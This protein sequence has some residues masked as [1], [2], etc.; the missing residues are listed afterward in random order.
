MGV[1]RDV[2]IADSDEEAKSLWENSAVF[3]G[4]NWF[5]PFGFFKGI[6]DPQTGAMPD[7]FEEGLVL[8]GTVDTVTRQL[9]RLLAR[10]PAAWIFAWL[11]NG[12][13]SNDRL[14]K[15]IELFYTKVLPRVSDVRPS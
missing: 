6:L 4:D 8:V 13:L 2:I 1:L 12:F 5:E 11:Y 7:V 14:K 10:L 15:T 9:E 3:V